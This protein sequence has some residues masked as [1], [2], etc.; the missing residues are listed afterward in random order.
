M[1]ED[2]LLGQFF[3]EDIN[4]LEKIAKTASIGKSDTVLEIGAGDGRLTKILAQNAKKVIAIEID[5]KFASALE[6]MPKNVEV[7]FE[8]VLKILS[9]KPLPKFTKI[10]GNLPS[11]LVEPLFQKLIKKKFKL[12]VFL[13]PKKFAH[14]IE[15]HPVFCL[16]F[17]TKLVEKVPKIAFQPVP[18]TNWEIV[19][20]TKKKDPL[21]TGDLNLYLRRF[22]YGHPKAKLKNALVE[23]LIRFY[24]AKGKKLTK[25]QARKLIIK[26]PSE[27]EGVSCFLKA[28]RKE[29][30]ILQS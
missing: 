19:L 15:K 27:S 2:V 30:F 17:D 28:S 18:R 5:Q 9:K 26:T 20:V 16:Y 12:A 13:V 11:S 24:A 22:V 21:K 8:D 29:A 25:N 10:L 1:R 4:I 3:L 6:K 14:K 7:I 23:G